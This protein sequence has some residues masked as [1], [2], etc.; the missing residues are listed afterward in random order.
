MQKNTVRFAA[1][2][3]LISAG[4]WASACGGSDTS[5]APAAAGTAGAGT[6][7]TGTSGTGGSAGN[8]AG[9]SSGTS[10]TGGSLDVSCGSMQCT[11]AGFGTLSFPACCP[12][13][14]NDTC[15][16]DSSILAMYGPSFADPCL[17]LH[18]PGVNDANCPPRTVMANGLSVPLPGC[19]R[20]DTGTCGYNLDNPG[21]LLPLNL[22]CVDSTPFLDGGAP[23]TCGDGGGGAAGAPN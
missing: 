8:Q 2:A 9:G 1:V 17:P 20:S 21:G 6:A 15:G 7:G 18:A 22:G 11:H 3:L 14:T 4:M 12:T 10:G 5:G 16:L 19:C 23:L 13:G